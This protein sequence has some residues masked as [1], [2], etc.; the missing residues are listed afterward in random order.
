MTRPP[1]PQTKS[2]ALAVLRKVKPRKS[3]FNHYDGGD[4]KADALRTS[5]KA[6]LQYATGLRS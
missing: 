3:H 2:A 1:S 5:Q 4:R 6:A